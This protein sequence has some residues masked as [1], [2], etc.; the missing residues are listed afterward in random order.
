ML[1]QYNKQI[2]KE[3]ICIID[4]IEKAGYEAYIVGGCVRDLLM[5][6]TPHDWDITTS[7]KPEQVKEVFRRTYDTGIKH[8]TV[9]VILNEQHFEVTTYRI[10][11]E[12]KDFRRPE[13]VSFVED[14][15]LD[16]SRRDFTMNAIAYHPVRGFVDPYHGQEAIKKGYISSVRC[17]KERFTEDALRILRAVRFSAQLGFSIDEDTIQ[18]IEAC[19][20]LLTHISKE[21]IRDE[22]LKICV[23]DRPTHINLLRKLGLLEYIIPEFIKTYDT[24]QN[25]PHHIY[26]VAQ[27]TLVAMENVEPTIRLRL[28]MLL[29][30]LGKAYTRTTDKNGIDHFYNHPKKSVELAGKILRELKL[31]NRMIKEVSSLIYFHDYHIKHTIDKIYVK[32]MLMEIGPELFDELM[33]VQLA[34][35]RSQNPDKLEPKIKNIEKQKKLKEEVMASN[36]PY[37]KSMLAIT[38]S[39][40]MAAGIPRGKEIGWLLDEALDKVIRDPLA[41]EKDKLISYCQKIYGNRGEE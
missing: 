34:D 21:R 24:P 23:S 17:A 5:G 11:G 1:T 36:E 13:E 19:K 40:L 22:F 10:E 28:T 7:A 26:H 31:D 18:G 6:R 27:H 2:P 14:I 29:H 9:T 35:A 20:E 41:N 4:T 3:A 12:Y 8:G 16:L 30:D 15:T 39:D 25:H 37:Q 33:K 32:K 38:G